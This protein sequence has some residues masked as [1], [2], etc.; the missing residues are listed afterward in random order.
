MGPPR[1]TRR[2]SANCGEPH[3][4]SS[5]IVPANVYAEPMTLPAR[6]TVAIIGAG[7]VGLEAA[8]RSLDAGLDLHVF[9]RG[10]VGAHALAWGHV[11]MF[12]PWRMNLGSASSARLTAAGWEPPDPDALPTGLELA[13]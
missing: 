7:P 9:E 4:A 5:S 1:T 8:V 3:G 12:T 10:E 11:H 13:E 2:S 6:N